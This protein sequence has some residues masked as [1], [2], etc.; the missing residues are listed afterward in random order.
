MTMPEIEPQLAELEVIANPIS[1]RSRGWV[2][3][4]GTSRGQC[5]A[6]WA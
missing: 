3:N 2:A 4:A 1:T 6:T 5:P